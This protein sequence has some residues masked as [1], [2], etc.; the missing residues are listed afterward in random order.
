M[1]L[2]SLVVKLVVVRMLPQVGQTIADRVDTDAEKGMC[3]LSVKC[4]F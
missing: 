1:N 4:D 2:V 3:E